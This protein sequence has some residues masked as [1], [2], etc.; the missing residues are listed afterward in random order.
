MA[1]HAPIFT[2]TFSLCEWLLRHLDRE[3]SVLARTICT[4]ALTFLEVITLA[5][6]I[7]YATNA[8]TKPTNGCLPCACTCDS[9]AA[10][11]CSTNSSCCLLWSVPTA[12]A[13]N[14][15]VGNG[16]GIRHT[17][18]R[19]VHQTPAVIYRVLRGIGHLVDQSDL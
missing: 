9:P 17:K 14:W 5:L 10:L 6:K 4:T 2:D 19:Q 12:L 15:V 7:A 8:S 3:P 1:N 16:R 18:A 11:G 13:A